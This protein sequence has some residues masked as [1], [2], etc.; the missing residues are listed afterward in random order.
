MKPVDCMDVYCDAEFYDLEFERRDQEIPFFLK[1]AQ[2][3][4]GPILE[5]CCGTGRITLPIARMRVPITG[6]DISGPMLAL[7]R[8]KTEAENLSI[9]WIERDCRDMRIEGQFALAFSATNA[10]QHLLDLGSVTSFLGSVHHALRPQGSLIIDVFNPDPA[11]LA[12]WPDKPYLHKTF[13]DRA[14]QTIRVEAASRYTAATQILSFDL[15]Y[16]RD[17][18]LIKTKH[19]QMRCFF[20][21]ELMAICKFNGFKIVERFGDYDETPFS[22]T[23]PK[24]ILVCE[25]IS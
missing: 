23:S 18:E 10:M 25:A 2:M 12:R 8:R 24:Q 9:E 21:E 14:G 6:L 11:K 15:R 17:R 13:T 3:T 5:I 1:R 19:V 4:G 7:A 20:P 22:D 16:L